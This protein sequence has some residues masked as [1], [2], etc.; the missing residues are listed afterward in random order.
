MTGVFM[1]RDNRIKQILTLLNQEGEVQVTQLCRLFNVTEMTI[2]RDLESLAQQNILIR[3]HGGAFL[4]TD[5]V[6]IEAPFEK[7][8]KRN[9]EQKQAIAI[10]ANEFIK[11]GAKIVMDS[12]STTFTI[13]SIISSSLRLAVLTN[14]LNIAIE[15][16][17]RV[18]IDTT[19]A[20]GDVNKNTMACVGSST[21]ETIKN[22][23]ADIAFIGASGVGHNGDFFTSRISQADIKRAMLSIASIK[24]MVVDSSKFAKN[25][26]SLI[27]DASQLSYV[28]TDSSASAE[29][30]EKIITAGAEV[31]LV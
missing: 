5:D 7:R 6:L 8:H 24:I 26:Y 15:L 27:T 21:I 17:S 10:K 12:E 9:T 29:I 2:R 19:F 4:A 16:N 11:S 20:G 23:R 3:T 30:V 28:I 14:D 1:L 22:Y 18:R 13:A 31:I 25:D